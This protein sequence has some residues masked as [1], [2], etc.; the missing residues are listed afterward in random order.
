MTGLTMLLFEG[1]WKTLDFGLEKWLNAK[2]DLMSHH[3]SIED[4]HAESNVDY[5]GLAQ[6]VSEGNNIRDYSC[7]IWA[8]NVTACWKKKIYQRIK[9]KCF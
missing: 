1:M 6:E 9:L 4:D 3:S 2:W 5:G 8:T 7:D